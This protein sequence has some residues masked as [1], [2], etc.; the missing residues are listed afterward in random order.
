M[1]HDTF[2]D[3]SDNDLKQVEFRF[4]GRHIRTQFIALNISYD[5]IHRTDQDIAVFA[6][7][8]QKVD[9]LIHQDLCDP[10]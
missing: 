5:V 6:V 9:R 2:T 3:I 10:F 4:A 8:T 1:G 7:I